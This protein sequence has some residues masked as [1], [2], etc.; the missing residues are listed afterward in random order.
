MVQGKNNRKYHT[1]DIFTD[2]TFAT[3]N[4]AQISQLLSCGFDAVDPDA[5]DNAP[6]VSTAPAQE[7]A[8]AQ[9]EDDLPF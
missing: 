4:E 7:S 2:R 8:N 1:W 9:E 3:L 6:A 5:K